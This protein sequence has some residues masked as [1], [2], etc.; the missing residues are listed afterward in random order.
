MYRVLLGALTYSAVRRYRANNNTSCRLFYN[1]KKTLSFAHTTSG[2]VMG[3]MSSHTSE[4][5]LQEGDS[6]STIGP[7]LGFRGMKVTSCSSIAD[8][9]VTAVA[10]NVSCLAAIVESVF[11]HV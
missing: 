3:K 8:T 11:E 9:F 1:I 10:T 4:R 6:S 7:H 2:Q 5:P